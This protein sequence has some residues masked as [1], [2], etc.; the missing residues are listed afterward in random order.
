ME[1]QFQST[2]STKALPMKISALVTISVFFAAT[3]H[4]QDTPTAP[5]DT[6]TK[7]AVRDSAFK[8]IPVTVSAK[9]EGKPSVTRL[10]LPVTAS[11]TAERAQE[12]VNLIDVQDAVKY[13][14]SVFLRKRNNGDTQA[15][16]ATRVWGVGSSARNLIFA[17]GVPLSALI[18]NNNTIGGPRW[19]LVSPAEIERIDMMY[20]PFSAG[21]AGNS[22]GAVMEI[23]TRLPER[24]QGS[25]NQT[26]AFQTFNLYG[27]KDTYSTTQTTANI[28][29]RFDKFSF[30]ASGNY[31]NSHSQPLSY[32]TAAAFPTGTTGG[33]SERNKLGSPA[34]VLGASGLLHT[35]MSNGK[36][37]AAYDFTPAIRAAYTFGFWKNDADAA[38]DTYSQTVA[39]G[40]PTFA[41]Q[42]GFAS[43]NYNLLEQ[44][45]SHSLSLR[46]DTRSDWDFEAVA[47]LYHFDKD[48]Q[49]TP[50]SAS[51]TGTTFGQV[52]RVAVLDGTGWSTVD[53][54]ALWRRGGPASAHA[55]SFG[56]H[57]DHYKLVNTTYN[58]ANWMVG[59]P[60]TGVAT[61]GDGKTRTNAV[62]AQD[63]WRI[64][65]DLKLTFGGRYEDFRGYDGFNVN[66]TTAI[67]QPEVKATRFSPKGSLAWTG[68]PEWSVT[69]SVGRAYR[70][71][72]AAELYQLVSTGTTFT[73]PD[74]NL[75][76]DNVLAAELRIKR[77]IE[78]GIVE[79]ALF[80]DDIHDAIISQF[81]PLVPGSST[82]FSFV[83]N[84][85]HVRARG[86][87]LVVGRNDVL[88]RGLELSGNVTYLNARTLALSGAAS[89]NAPAGSAVG[90]RLPNIPEWRGQFTSTYRPD[91]RLALT[92]AGRYSD[93][94]YTTLDN[95]DVNPNT[96]QGFASWFVADAHINYKVD[97]HW[98]AAVGV[99]NLLNRKY[100]LFHPFPQRTFVAD[101]KFGF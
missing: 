88:I 101:V 26:Q 58:T 15:T 27:T 1:E 60:Y 55:V 6:A 17:D 36:I 37:K 13:L 52:G 12:T 71:A 64:M 51:S 18:A 5:T 45:T 32:V 31:Q 34:N 25:V 99:D 96:Y 62:W 70:F 92:L 3:V 42:S 4:A 14:P 73:S 97:R 40:Q 57:S 59:A 74:P 90:K 53:L 93:K 29:N 81:R 30:W 69:A 98:T 24:F 66:G 48:K 83:S 8:L 35:R 43:G 10:T 65:P 9:V 72:T 28:G 63:S 39:S 86:V 79:L 56:V 85:D 84:I 80:Q 50:T 21:Y 46:T 76:P 61:E 47:A 23:T 54:K 100:F 95:A 33:F 68:R 2:H 49:R 94:L 38:V 67:H 78:Q 20:G 77:R 7:R 87:E 75:K 11:V 89:A 22:M 19:G 44:H 16:M 82:L 41:G 91:D